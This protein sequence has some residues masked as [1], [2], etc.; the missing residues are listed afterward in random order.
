MV[1]T[2]CSVLRYRNR[3]TS[4]LTEIV[5]VELWESKEFSKPDLKRT[6]LRIPLN[7]IMSG[8]ATIIM[9]FEVFR[10]KLSVCP[11][12]LQQVVSQIVTSV[13]GVE[14]HQDG[15][16]VHAANIAYQYSEN[17]YLPNFSLFH[18]V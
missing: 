7:K 1:T 4:E 8:S 16:V 5:P 17:S 3:R 14:S 11:A 10:Y 6:Y 13:H 15:V 9:P 18:V 12:T 2:R